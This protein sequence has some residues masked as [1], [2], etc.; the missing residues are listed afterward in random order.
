M[1]T[2][3]AWLNALMRAIGREMIFDKP[4]NYQTEVQLHE[5]KVDGRHNATY[6]PNQAKECPRGALEAAN[7]SWA[8]H[9]APL[10]DFRQ[11]DGG[12][13]LNDCP[14]DERQIMLMKRHSCA[15]VYA[16]HGLEE[17]S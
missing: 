8:V 17:T 15:R 3:R 9:D 16:A 11:I 2:E 10:K 13:G 14:R 6:L 1:A 4:R 7:L 12:H 5:L